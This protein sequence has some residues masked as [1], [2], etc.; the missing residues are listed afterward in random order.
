MFQLGKMYVSISMNILIK[1]YL[2]H[3][4]YS[5]YANSDLQ[6]LFGFDTVQDIIF[7]ISAVTT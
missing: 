4:C 5:F 3:L 7:G 6:E 1:L 2:S